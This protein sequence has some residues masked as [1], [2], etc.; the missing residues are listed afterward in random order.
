MEKFTP[1]TKRSKNARR[2]QDRSR[3]AEWGAVRP[4]TRRQESAKTYNRKKA[5]Q[6]KQ[7]SGAGLFIYA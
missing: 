4:V 7:D 2:E 1:Y 3:R 6:W 5:R